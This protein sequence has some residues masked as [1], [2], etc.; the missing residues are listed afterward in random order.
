LRGAESIY[1]LPQMHN[2]EEEIHPISSSNEP[3]RNG[4]LVLVDMREDCFH[5]L[6][7]R[8]TDHGNDRHSVSPTGDVKN[9]MKIAL[10]IAVKDLFRQFISHLR[11]AVQLTALT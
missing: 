2:V 6:Q 10:R 5:R 3:R 8:Y 11:I 1:G 7:M 9:A 4:K